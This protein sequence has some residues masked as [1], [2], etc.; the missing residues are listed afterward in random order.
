M[1][2]TESGAIWLSPQRTSP[3]AFY[4][5]WVNVDDAE[6]GMCLRF[7]TELEH[8]EIEALDRSRAE[9]PNRRASQKS[10]AEEL[11]RLIHGE[12]GLAKALTAT[13]VFFGAEISQLSDSDLAEI[14]ADVPGC[15]LS[16]ND[17]D[18][19]GLPVVDAFAQ[20]GLCR[21]KGEA[22]RTI[23]EGGAYVNNLRVT[24]VEARLTRSDLAERNDDRT[25]PREEEVRR[26]AIALNSVRRTVR[27]ARPMSNSANYSNRIEN[28]NELELAMS[29]YFT[30]SAGNSGALVD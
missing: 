18:G 26:T 21:S 17:L 4:Q 25:A 16:S 10:L 24:D 1:G 30:E 13:K 2:K 3:Y 28:S 20:S 22:R 6:A 12:S 9:E 15:E 5:Y 23:Q 27:P 19:E 8:D 14:F 11:T 7:M 29:I